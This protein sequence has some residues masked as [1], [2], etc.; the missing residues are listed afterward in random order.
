MY[1][2]IFKT[3]P[4][5]KEKTSW[6]YYD[7]EEDFRSRNPTCVFVRMTK[8]KRKPTKPREPGAKK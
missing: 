5:L 6:G 8:Q 4:H 1:K 2:V 3:K 7:N